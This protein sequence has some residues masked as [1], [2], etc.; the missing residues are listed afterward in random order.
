MTECGKKIYNHQLNHQYIYIKLYH[1][2]IIAPNI[3]SLR[4]SLIKL[5]DYSLAYIIALFKLLSLFIFTMS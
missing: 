4:I 3:R 5:T 1:L 2:S